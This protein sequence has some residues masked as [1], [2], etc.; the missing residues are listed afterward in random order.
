MRSDDL[1]TSERFLQHVHVE[2]EMSTIERE[3]EQTQSSGQY[4]D[5]VNN[6]GVSTIATRNPS[7]CTV[8]KLGG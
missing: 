8:L 1:W 5:P 4:V 2:C 6:Q 7:K 3:N